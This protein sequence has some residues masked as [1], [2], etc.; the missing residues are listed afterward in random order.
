MAHASKI[1]PRKP[2]APAHSFQDHLHRRALAAPRRHTMDLLLDPPPAQATSPPFRPLVRPNIHVLAI[3]PREFSA[4]IEKN[5]IGQHRDDLKSLR[6]CALVCHDWHVRSRIHIFSRHLRI[7]GRKQY[8]DICSYF[9]AH[10]FLGPLVQSF[11]ISSEDRHSASEFISTLLFNRIS[12]LCELSLNS[13]SHSWR[14]ERFHRSI[15]MYLTYQHSSIETLRLHNCKF[16]NPTQLVGL[17]TSLTRLQHLYCFKLWTGRGVIGGSARLQPP[18]LG[19][20]YKRKPNKLLSL[21]V[22]V[23]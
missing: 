6:L 23:T 3:F 21:S 20:A 1:P 13:G 2:R 17:L 19:L 4:E 22:S 10:G 14:P 7:R 18:Q 8:E 9:Q 12:N 16:E 15:L 11:E 5:I